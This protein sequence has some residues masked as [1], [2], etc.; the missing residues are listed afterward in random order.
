MRLFHKRWAAPAYMLAKTV[1][2]WRPGYLATALLVIA[3]PALADCHMVRAA[4]IPLLSNLRP[5]IK[6]SINGK[7]VHMVVDTGA[8]TSSVTP[9]TASALRLPRDT[10]RRRIIRSIGG[11]DITQDAVLK[12]LSVSSIHY[13][14]RNVAVVALDG[15]RMGSSLAGIIGA[16]VLTGFDIELD[17]PRRTLTLY[18]AVGCSPTRPPWRGQYQTV[19]ARVSNYRQFLFPVELNGHSVTALFD[20][21]SRGETVSRATARSIGV[22]DAQLDKDPATFGTSGGLHKYAIR[23]HRF[24][25]FRIGAETFRDTP[26]DVVD[27]HQ[28]GVDMLVGADYMHRHRFFLSYSSGLLFIQTE[29]DEAS[30]RQPTRQPQADR[31]RHTYQRSPDILLTE[32]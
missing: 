9:E 7:P 31:A 16:D 23:R 17:I 13:S 11:Q 30:R 3:G 26:L 22:T 12:K 2:R 5:V 29:R 8:Q 15:S 21:G 1:L 19:S 6:V 24:D 25:T 20:T 18:R 4:T 28:P 10:N 32:L 27:F 14:N